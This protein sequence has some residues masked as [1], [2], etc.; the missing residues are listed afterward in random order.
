MFIYI[1]YVVS[2]GAFEDLCKIAETMYHRKRTLA[3]CIIKKDKLCSDMQILNKNST[4][5]VKQNSEHLVLM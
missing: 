5:I 1:F 4:Q 3:S 2:R